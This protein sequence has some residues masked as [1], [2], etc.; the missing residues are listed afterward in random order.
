M[1]ATFTV[2]SSLISE[3]V[4]LKKFKDDW[5]YDR[6]KRNTRTKLTFNDM[7]K[8]EFYIATITTPE[9]HAGK[10]A[11]YCGIGTY[12][13]L[14]VDS[15]AYTLG[16]NAVEIANTPDFRGNGI[17]GTLRGL[18]N[19]EVERRADSSNLP[20]LVLLQTDSRAHSYYGSREYAT[21]TENIPE[22]A[23]NR[24]KVTPKHWFVYNENEPVKKAWENVLVKDDN[25]EWKNILKRAQFTKNF[26]LLKAT[27]LSIYQE[28]E[29]GEEI[30]NDE[31]YEKFPEH[32]KKVANE[33]DI[34]LPTGS[35]TGWYKNKGYNWVQAKAMMIGKNAGL[36]VKGYSTVDN[37]QRVMVAKRV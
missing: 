9:E 6:A 26:K 15:G 13:D 8:L 10:I 34:E 11:G 25:K 22:W 18:R 1:K 24:V 32:I 35:F 28:L 16:G 33:L 37:R 31:V 36:V 4:M 14:L 12:G 17:Y 19:G 29:V 27:V 21:N 20:F 23:L 3:D 7:P 5:G 2:S 30:T